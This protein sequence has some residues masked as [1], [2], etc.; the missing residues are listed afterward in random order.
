M[1]SRVILRGMKQARH[2]LHFVEP[3]LRLRAEE[4]RLAIEL[5]HHAEVYADPDELFEHRP[6]SGIV[7][8]HEGARGTG[9]GS[10]EA[11]FARMEQAGLWLPLIAAGDEPPIARIVAAVK[12]GALDYLPLPLDRRRLAE[13]LERVSREAEAH[14]AAR[15]RMFEARSLIS[16]LSQREREVLDW[17]AEGNSN[18]VIAR[19]LNISPRT[20]EIHR[21]NMLGKLGA[22][23][24][25]E[26]V[27]MR[28]ES[29]LEN[30][31]RAEGCRSR[32]N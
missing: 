28:L 11:L 12:A 31:A 4:A 25:V 14:A 29:E 27:R 13:A 21:A 26:A 5:G 7:I 2:T 17:L 30:L 8:V 32:P 18:K 10:V 15:R 22:K 1:A 6:H 9:A 20:V 16:G 24:S 19:R 3:N 23:H